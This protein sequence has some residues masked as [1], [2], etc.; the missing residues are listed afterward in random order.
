MKP[1]SC[2]YMYAFTFTGEL[3]A[4]TCGRWDCPHC[5]KTNA[6]KWAIRVRIHLELRDQTA[7]FWTV[8]LRGKFKTAEEGYEAL[9]GLWD[10]F[11]KTIQRG[12]G[13]EWEYCAFVEGQPRRRGMPHFHII[14]MGKC[15]KRLKDVAME[16][17]FGYQAKEEVVNSIRAALYVTKY[18]SKGDRRM[19]KNFRRCRACQTWSKLPPAR[20][21]PL[22]VQAK[23]EQIQHYLVRVADISG[24]D[25]DSLYTVWGARTNYI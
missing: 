11:R 14:S 2:P 22:I 16:C 20:R 8:T 7:Y 3:R 9:P 25:L 23:D 4:V 24:K 5:S 21:Q 19:P 10:T 18:A 15:P 17:G 13:K 1:K 6:N 12:L